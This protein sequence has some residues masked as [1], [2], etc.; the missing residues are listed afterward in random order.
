MTQRTGLATR[1]YFPVA[2][3]NGKLIDDRTF[4]EVWTRV[5]LNEILDSYQLT[6]TQHLLENSDG[7]YTASSQFSEVNTQDI[8][9]GLEWGDA[10]IRELNLDLRATLDRSRP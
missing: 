10:P 5:W 6:F 4:G 2:N 7:K 1:H 9:L 8:A 3:E